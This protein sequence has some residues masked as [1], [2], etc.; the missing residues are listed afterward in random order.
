MNDN[1]ILD[2]YLVDK[3]ERIKNLEKDVAILWY[4]VI[5]ISVC[6][7]VSLIAFSG[8]LENLIAY[9]GEAL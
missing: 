6:L 5:S 1:E 9:M 8:I 3:N 2:D 7:G 4:V